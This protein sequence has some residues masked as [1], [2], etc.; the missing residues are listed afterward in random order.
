MQ[1]YK[2]QLSDELPKD[3]SALIEKMLLEDPQ[4]RPT[5]QEAFESLCPFRPKEEFSTFENDEKAI[6]FL[7]SHASGGNLVD[8]AG[9]K[10]M[11]LDS[12]C[13]RVVSEACADCDSCEE[14][15]LHNASLSNDTSP[16]LS[17]AICDINVQALKR[18]K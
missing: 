18:G 2:L 3:V 11:H 10:S 4:K 5:A 15:K 9:E 1:G 7:R 6:H 8:A 17:Q 16:F 12:M 13:G 14:E